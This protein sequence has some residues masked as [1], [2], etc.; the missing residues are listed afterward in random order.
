MKCGG[1][2]ECNKTYRDLI[3]HLNLN[4]NRGLFSMIRPTKNYMQPTEVHLDMQ[5]Y[6]ILDVVE[7]EQKFASYVLINMWW[8]DDYL[9]WEPDNFC[10]MVEICLPTK[11]LW[12][13]DLTVKEMTEKD[14]A[15]LSPYLMVYSSGIIILQNDMMLV[16]TCKMHVYKF[17]FDTQSCNLTFKSIVYRDDQMVLHAPG[18]PWKQQAGEMLGTQSDWL[19]INIT[20]TENHL[21]KY[22]I[23]QRE[24]IYTVT[25]K[26]RPILYTVNFILPVFFFLCLDF[27]SFLI[28]E[29]GGEKLSFK[30][31]V[32]LAVTVMQ[33][34]L[35]EILPS[36]SDAVPLIA[37]YC[38]GIFGLMMISLLE[39]ILVMYLKERDSAPKDNE[40]KDHDESQ[41]EDGG[42]ACGK[43]SFYH[44][45]EED[46]VEVAG[47]GAVGLH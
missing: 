22:G 3:T 2:S 31:T 12:I 17:P 27:A 29:R 34:I 1:A 32:M 46:M 23:H 39:T 45:F 33:L 28:S 30:V 43:I 36:S 10:G 42:K 47:T 38:V 24:I 19:L 40:T 14:K 6:A 25:M 18:A 5:L 9:Q 44:C 21:G 35:H 20:V 26:R 37:V 7:K 11:Q 4:Q 41:G 13:P 16:T 15:T 8:T